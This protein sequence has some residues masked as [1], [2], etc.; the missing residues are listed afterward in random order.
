MAGHVGPIER[1]QRTRVG[2]LSRRE[3]RLSLNILR[4]QKRISQ[5][6]HHRYSSRR[7]RP[8]EAPCSQSQI[9]CRPRQNLSGSAL[10]P[11][12]IRSLML[13]QKMSR[14]RARSF[15]MAR[16]MPQL[17]SKATQLNL[18]SGQHDLGGKMIPTSRRMSSRPLAV[19][20][21]CVPR[22]RAQPMPLSI[23]TQT[24]MGNVPTQIRGRRLATGTTPV[25]RRG[26]PLHREA[27][28]SRACTTS[29]A[30]LPNF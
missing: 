7:P 9:D 11:R 14:T 4:M 5:F 26:K 21:L 1:S 30:R 8:R 18:Y 10:L 29:L 22:H 3:I 12:A 15:L 16:Q 28:A 23:S 27:R 2:R 25:M 20:Q 13:L 19:V 6:T 17:A 24:A